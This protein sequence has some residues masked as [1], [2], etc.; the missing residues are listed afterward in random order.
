[1]EKR[2]AKYN[3]ISL[4]LWYIPLL[5]CEGNITINFQILI[6]NIYKTIQTMIIK[7]S[8]TI[9]EWLHY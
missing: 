8:I 9:S 7:L 6:G 4:Y 5:I 2:T 1:M 3:M